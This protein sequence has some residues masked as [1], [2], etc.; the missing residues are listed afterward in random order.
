MIPNAKSL[1]DELRRLAPMLR[2]VG[3]DVRPRFGVICVI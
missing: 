3:V 2:T 1:S